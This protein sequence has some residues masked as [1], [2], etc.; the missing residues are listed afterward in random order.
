MIQIDGP[1]RHVY[2]KLSD[3]SRMQD[4]LTSTTG[5][6]EYRHNWCHFQ[7]KDRSRGLRL[8]ESTGSE[9]ST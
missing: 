8:A 9:P 5:H 6:S 3:P 4:L 1:K 2:I 7:G